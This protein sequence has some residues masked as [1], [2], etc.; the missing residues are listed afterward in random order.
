M[1]TE[2]LLAAVDV[3]QAN[4][5]QQSTMASDIL[6]DILGALQYR[7]PQ[8]SI[9]KVAAPKLLELQAV[10]PGSTLLED[11]LSAAL[12]SQLPPGLDGH[13]AF[14]EG[15]PLST[16]LSSSKPTHMNDLR[17][18]PFNLISRMLEKE[19][20]T[21]STASAIAALLYSNPTSI[22][23]Y[24]TWLNSQRWTRLSMHTFALVLVAF[25][26]CTGLTGGDLSQ[27]DDDALDGLLNHL[28]MGERHH[29]SRLTR[30]LECIH[31]ILELSGTR[32]ARLVSALQDRIQGFPIMDLAFETTFLARKLFG[33]SDCGALTT[34]I[35]DR[36]LQW[37]VR[38]LS[39]G[40]SDSGDLRMALGNLSG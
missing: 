4:S 37:A 40:A 20:W 33:V 12:V 31:K 19:T 21:D 17:S 23:A 29:G 13:I 11:M 34:S 1:G 28:I 22:Q 30:H 35:V 24:V 7:T 15:Q 14:I 6:E 25:L 18:L 27:V 26:E 32:S 3:I 16:V 36:A 10:L 8:G 38:Q 39:G 2:E 9:P 5:G